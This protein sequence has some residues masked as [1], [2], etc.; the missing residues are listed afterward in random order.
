MIYRS[1][2]LFV[3]FIRGRRVVRP[4]WSVLFFSFYPLF[5]T[6]GCVAGSLPA[7]QSVSFASGPASIR[8]FGH[9]EDAPVLA[10]WRVSVGPPVISPAR[11]NLA[12]A[13]DELTVVSW[14]T[15]LG[16]GDI[17]RF[18]RSLPATRPLVLLLQEVYRGGPEVPS[19]LPSDAVYARRKGGAAASARY[20]EIESVAAALGLSLYYV[21]S[22]RNGSPAASSE[23]RGNAVLSSL[24]LEDLAA[25]ELPFERQRRVAVAGTVAGYASSGIPWRL[26]L[27]NAHFDNTFDPRRLW[28]AAEYGRTR[29]ARGLLSSLGDHE[30]LILGGDFNTWAG[31]SDQAYLTLARQFPATRV[32]DRRATFLGVLRLDHIF[33]RLEP[34]WTA[35]VRRADNRFGSD[36]SPLIAT[37]RVKL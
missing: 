30:P 9:G 26:R 14:N 11:D 20:E 19:V 36:H 33:F 15:A 1:V 6:G 12:G 17:P 5:A 25:F 23:D 37:V 7:A 28:L 13:V 4:L 10:R 3:M 27:V 34:G 21:P 32:T 8:W 2:D 31:F 18:V 35:T 29:Q 22:M 16:A 24:P